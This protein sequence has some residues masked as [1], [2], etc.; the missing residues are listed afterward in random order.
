MIGKF[1]NFIRN[2]GLETLWIVRFVIFSVALQILIFLFLSITKLI[3]RNANFEL[4]YKFSD[5]LNII[6]YSAFFS[7]FLYSII[8]NKGFSKILK[9]IFRFLFFC[10]YVNM[11]MNYGLAGTVIIPQKYNNWDDFILFEN[12]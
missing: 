2:S 5:T 6:F 4:D 9:S 10:F 7:V 11:I 8:K 3:L 12:L 1:E